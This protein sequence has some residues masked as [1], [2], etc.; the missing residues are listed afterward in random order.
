MY[1]RCHKN[2]LLTLHVYAGPV[3]QFVTDCTCGYLLS[4]SYAESCSARAK[5]E[6]G[7]KSGKKQVFIAITSSQVNDTDPDSLL[8]N[9]RSEITMRLAIALFLIPLVQFVTDC[10]CLN[11]SAISITHSFPI[12]SASVCCITQ[13]T[14]K[15]IFA[16]LAIIQA[17]QG[18]KFFC[19]IKVHRAHSI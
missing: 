14:D 16:K 8:Y 4:S 10:T 2:R 3:V 17:K 6:V 5:S 13:L 7:S 9:A 15:K 1:F 18:C 19:L 12:N 11:P